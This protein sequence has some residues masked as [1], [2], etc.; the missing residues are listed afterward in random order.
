LFGLG[1]WQ[2]ARTPTNAFTGESRDW[3]RYFGDF[4]TP[5]VWW[6]VRP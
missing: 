6:A 4:S 2:V 5:A 3:K 1:F